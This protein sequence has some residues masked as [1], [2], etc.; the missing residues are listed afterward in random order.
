VFT[1]VD[2]PIPQE[3]FATVYSYY[4]PTDCNDAPALVMGYAPVCTGVSLNTCD[5]T[6]YTVAYYFQAGNCTTAPTFVTSDVLQP[7]CGKGDGLYQTITCE[8]G[9][10]AS[11][12]N[13][14]PMPPYYA[15]IYLNSYVPGSCPDPFV[16]APEAWYY[17]KIDT[18]IPN[19]WGGVGT[20]SM[21]YIDTGISSIPT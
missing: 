8:S 12:N 2:V 19:L 15:A 20:S 21:V 1:E 16:E 6:N 11:I 3:Q 13:P 14:P 4:S 18:C 5:G 7:T 10:I 9:S 17:F